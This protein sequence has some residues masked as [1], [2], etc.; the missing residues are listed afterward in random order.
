[1]NG[2]NHLSRTVRALLWLA[3]WSLAMAGMGCGSSKGGA[4][5][6]GTVKYQ[7]KSLPSGTVTFFDAKKNIVGSASIKD[8]S[9]A[10][11]GVPP[12]KVNVSVTTPPAVTVDP[13]H[14]VPKGQ[15]ESSGPPPV[16]IPQQY[17]NPEKSGLT[18]DVKPGKTNDYPIELR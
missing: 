1:M 3:V 15:A 12:G 9:Y 2:S 11:V 7:G 18:Y 8:G 10:M 6:S 13:A 14:P 17:G 4:K 5:V 16:P